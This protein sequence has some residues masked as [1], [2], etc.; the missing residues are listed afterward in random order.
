MTL[1]RF[2]AHSGIGT[3]VQTFERD[4][5]SRHFAVPIFPLINSAD[6]CV[7]FGNQ[8]ALTISG[9]QLQSPIRFFAGPICNIGNIT[10]IVLQPFDRIA[11]FSEQILLPV[12]KFTTEILKLPIIHERLIFGRTVIFRQKH[13]LFHFGSFGIAHSVGLFN[14]RHTSWLPMPL[15]LSPDKPIVTTQ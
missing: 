4:W 1:L 11:A 5:L 13:F 3:R 7:D 12:Q 9:A 8:L 2:Q 10:G 15:R 14:L 6:R